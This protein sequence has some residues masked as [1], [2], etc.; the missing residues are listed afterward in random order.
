MSNKVD[1]RQVKLS[2]ASMFIKLMSAMR[3]NKT[4]QEFKLLLDSSNQY[5]VQ[6]DVVRQ[7]IYAAKL[8]MMLQ[9]LPCHHKSLIQ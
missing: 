8:I 2:T 9:L 3:Y 4:Q 1:I 7:E 6:R 5:K